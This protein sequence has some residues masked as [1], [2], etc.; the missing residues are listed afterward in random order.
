MKK[1]PRC[2]LIL[3]YFGQFNNYFPLFLR[4]CASNDLY[5]WLLVTD[6]DKK[7]NYPSNF[8]VIKMTLEEFKQIT[9]KKLQNSISL[10][11]PYKLCDYKPAY[12]LIFDSFLDG[13]DYWGHCDCDLIFGNLNEI[14][15]PLLEEG[16]DKLFAA[17]H[18]TIYKNTFE[19]NRRFMHL[20]NEK[21]LYKDVFSTREILAFDEDFFDENV[22]SIFVSE[23][24]N[25]FFG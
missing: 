17:G 21:L 5:N 10:E 25:V 15:T 22:H 7:Y 23:N 14:L 18:L 12:G 6:N 11:A 1:K 13:Y 19:N 16:Y 24:M 2:L 4:S 9:E 3:P 20:Y 8:K